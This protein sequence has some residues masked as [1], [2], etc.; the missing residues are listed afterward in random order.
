[1]NNPEKN[2]KEGLF[3]HTDDFI[4]LTET[5][6]NYPAIHEIDLKDKN[7][8][9]SLIDITQQDRDIVPVFTKSPNG[10]IDIIPA[11]SKDFDP[12]GEGYK[13]VY[14]GKALNTTEEK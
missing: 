1:M 6:R 12:K 7:H 14:L 3:S 10:S 13:L 4:K 5:V 8:Y 9:D 11:N 2:P